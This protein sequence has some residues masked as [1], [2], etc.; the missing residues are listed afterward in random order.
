MGLF[1]DCRWSDRVD[2]VFIKDYNNVQNQV[3]QIDLSEEKFK[4]Q[5]TDNI[6]GPSIVVVVYDNQKPIAARTLWR[7]DIDGKE[8]YQPVQ[9]CVMENY[10][11]QGVFSEMTRRA[12]SMIPPNAIVYNYPNINSF[13]AYVKLGWRLVKEYRPRLLLSNKRY[14]REHPLDID[15]KYF[16]WWIHGNDGLKYVR[17]MGKYYVCRNDTPRP[18]FHIL[19]RTTKELAIRLPNVGRLGVCFYN[20]A[21]ITFYN[22]KYQP[23]RVV[24]KG[25]IKDYIPIWKIDVL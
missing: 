19:G 8:A 9:T 6:Y 25:D 21:I 14:K 18:F 15:E 10:R 4:K 11:G 16:D 1:F 22:K 2:S 12:M 13:P 24:A 5:F 17:F 20:S 3:F 23:L 7:N